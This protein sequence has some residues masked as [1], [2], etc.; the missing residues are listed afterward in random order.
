MAVADE[1][2]AADPVHLDR[3]DRRTAALGQRQ[4]FPARAHPV[5]RGPKVPVEVAAGIDRAD[6]RVQRYRLQAQGPLAAHAERADD[7]V[8]SQ[9]AV[10]VLGPAAQAVGQRFGDLAPPGPQKVVLDVCLRES[11]I[12][13]R[14]SVGL[15]DVAP[16]SAD[17]YVRPQG[18]RASRPRSSSPAPMC[19]SG[20]RYWPKPG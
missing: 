2:L 1:M 6:D 8:E 4:L 3:R 7:F 10:A 12:E 17:A 14:G 11:G 13:H 16:G 20:Y 18:F 9:E 19:A 5:G 15:C